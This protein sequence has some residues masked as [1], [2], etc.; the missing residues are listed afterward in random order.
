MVDWKQ[1]FLDSVKAVEYN[2]K[3]ELVAVKGYINSRSTEDM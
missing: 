1:R 2:D 3:G